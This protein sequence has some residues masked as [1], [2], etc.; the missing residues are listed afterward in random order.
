MRYWAITRA[1]AV[2]KCKGSLCKTSIHKGDNVMEI[3]KI[4]EL[5]SGKKVN[6]KESYCLLC[7]TTLIKSNVKRLLE[8]MPVS[9]VKR[10]KNTKV[11]MSLVEELYPN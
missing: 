7:A 11:I 10:K 3:I 6:V 5:Y 1:K 8:M 2:R 4:E 9:D